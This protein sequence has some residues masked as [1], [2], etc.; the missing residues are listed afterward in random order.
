M[1]AANAA[2]VAAAAPPPPIN[3]PVDPHAAAMHFQSFQYCTEVASDAMVAAAAAVPPTAS[4]VSVAASLPA[5]AVPLGRSVYDTILP[6]SI[7]WK[8]SA[9]CG[10]MPMISHLKDGFDRNKPSGWH[11]NEERMARGLPPVTNPAAQLEG[12]ERELVWMEILILTGVPGGSFRH[13]ARAWGRDKG[14]HMVLAQ[15]ICERRGNVERKKRHRQRQRQKAAAASSKRSPDGTISNT[16][17]R[18]NYSHDDKQHAY[19]NHHQQPVHHQQ[20]PGQA[21]VADVW[22]DAGYGDSAYNEALA[23]D[24]LLF[25]D[26]ETGI[27]SSECEDGHF[28]SAEENQPEDDDGAGAGA[29]A[30]VGTGI[31]NFDSTAV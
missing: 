7:A 18:R 3:A 12:W 19:R 24:L 4:T 6:Q 5:S 26:D 27:S 8:A 23:A 10:R 2:S 28:Q 13:L 31:I 21:A 9:G 11:R 17:P 16:M 1:Q 29:G 30:G 22:D 15:F 14:F 20:Q 25:D